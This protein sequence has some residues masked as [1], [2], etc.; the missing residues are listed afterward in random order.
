MSAEKALSEEVARLT[1]I[2]DQVRAEI[3]RVG[4]ERSAQYRI[5]GWERES[6]AINLFTDELTARLTE[7]T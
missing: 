6:D 3:Q 5:D 4:R 7:T 2:L 1:A